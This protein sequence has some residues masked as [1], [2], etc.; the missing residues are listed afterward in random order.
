MKNKLFAL[1]ML[2]LTACLQVKAQNVP[3]FHLQ[4]YADLSI[5]NQLS[6]NGKW[7]V[8]QRGSQVDG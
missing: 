4:Q 2:V 6:D 8:A 7:A 5:A 3:T 1:W